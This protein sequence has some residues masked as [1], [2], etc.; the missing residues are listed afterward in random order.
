MSVKKSQEFG[1]MEIGFEITRKCNMTC[2]HCMRGEAQNHTI[3]KEVIN[4]FFDEVKSAYRMIFTGGE[5]FL[6]PEMIAYIVDTIIERNI[7]IR[8]FSCVTN[9]SIMSQSIVDSWN[10]LSEYIAERH[11]PLD[12]AESERKYLR[13]IGSITVSDDAFH[14]LEHDPMDTV[15]WY[16]ERLNKHC[17]IIKEIRK[18]EDKE[19]RV[20]ILGRAAADEALKDNDAAYYKVCPY[21]PEVED[22]VLKSCIMVG[23]DGKIMIGEDSSYEQQ[24]KY[25]YG[26]IMQAHVLTLIKKALQEE[27]FTREEAENYNLLQTLQKTGKYPEG[28]SKEVVKCFLDAFDATYASRKRGQEMFPALNYEEIVELAYDVNNIFYHDYYDGT[29]ILCIDTLTPYERPVEESRERQRK[30]I[31]KAILFNP[32]GFS[33]MMKI[34]STLAQVSSGRLNEADKRPIKVWD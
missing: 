28:W 17:I 9:G 27:V 24:D 3:S 29:K 20:H 21:R 2:R 34:F 11:T 15:K 31:S 25:N 12:D 4:K 26:N 10:R 13:A 1:C 18:D 30:L 19:S 5:P 7:D 14:Q 22:G 33:G 8:T 32:N 6:E 16:R 23:Y